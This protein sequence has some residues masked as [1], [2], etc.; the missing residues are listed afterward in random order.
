MNMS[1]WARAKSSMP[2]LASGYVRT[3][4]TTPAIQN[5]S[6][7]ARTTSEKSTCRRRA[8]L[9]QRGTRSPELREGE[10]HPRIHRPLASLRR[11]PRNDLIRVRDIAS[12]TVHAIGEVDYQLAR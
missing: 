3:R 6:M 2:R 1:F 12:L 10:L 7:S 5:A 4:S 8:T 9:L 11:D